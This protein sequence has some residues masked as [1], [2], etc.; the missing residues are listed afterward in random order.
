MIPP[1]SSPVGMETAL[2]SQPSRRIIFRT[3][4]GVIPM[5]WNCPIC[6][7]RDITEK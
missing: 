7:T 4:T 3:C 1:S 5:V 2:S 6:R